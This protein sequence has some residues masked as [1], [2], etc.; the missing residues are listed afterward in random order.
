MM[1]RYAV[2]DKDETGESL[3]YIVGSKEE[4]A[5]LLEPGSVAFP[6]KPGCPLS[7]S[8]G[9]PHGSDG[10]PET[11]EAQAKIAREWQASLESTP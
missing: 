8:N 7:A 1:A 5:E 2:I 3:A 9:I 6:L 11:G 10:K 4:A